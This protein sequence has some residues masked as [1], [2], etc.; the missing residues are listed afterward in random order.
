MGFLDWLRRLGAPGAGSG[1]GG[2]AH[3][4]TTAEPETELDARTEAAHGA[5]ARPGS[6]AEGPPV[7]VSDPG[8]FT[9][10]DDVVAAQEEDE[11]E[12]GSDRPT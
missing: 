10:E 5:G 6:A 4:H 11:L 9:G 3:P 8:S 2:D 7:G 12:P 1:E